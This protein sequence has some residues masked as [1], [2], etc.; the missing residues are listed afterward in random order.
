MKR[1]LQLRAMMLVIAVIALALE[2]YREMKSVVPS[3]CIYVQG[4]VERPGR[5][6]IT[7]RETVLD[8]I[9]RSGGLLT[10]SATA[11]ITLVRPAPPGACC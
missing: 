11:P 3:M 10:P 5:M 2:V 8:A 6:P 1:R 9:F 7:G 4:D